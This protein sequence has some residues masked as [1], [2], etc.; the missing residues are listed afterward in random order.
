MDAKTR[1][2]STRF[3]NTSKFLSVKKLHPRG[4]SISTI[5]KGRENGQVTIVSFAECYK[6]ST[7]T[8]RRTNSEAPCPWKPPH[9]CFLPLRK[10]REGNSRRLKH[11]MYP[12][13]KKSNQKPREMMTYLQM[14]RMETLV[15]SLSVS[16]VN[17]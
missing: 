11:R 9:G 1:R 12:E 17:L 6:A 10:L 16:R 7:K 5:L 2:D 3:A 8:R 15:N 14:G 4:C 13:K